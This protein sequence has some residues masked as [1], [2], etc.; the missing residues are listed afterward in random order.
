MHSTTIAKLEWQ[1][2]E[3]AHREDITTRQE[4]DSQRSYLHFEAELAIPWG[5]AAA[6]EGWL[7]KAQLCEETQGRK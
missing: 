4:K 7:G 6:W 3:D 5:E 1:W 2:S